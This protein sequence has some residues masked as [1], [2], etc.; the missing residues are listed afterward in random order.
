MYNRIKGMI[1][2]NLSFVFVYSHTYCQI[3]FT[4]LFQGKS[5]LKNYFNL[6]IILI[7]YININLN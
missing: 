6:L 7:L 3:K 5:T 1:T 2:Q 4:T